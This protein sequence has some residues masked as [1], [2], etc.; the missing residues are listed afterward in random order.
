MGKHQKVSRMAKAGIVPATAVA[1]AAASA[2]I[3]TAAPVELPPQGGVT[4]PTPSTQ[5]GTTSTPAPPAEPKYWTEA[6]VV[7]PEYA[8]LPNYDYDT[9]ESTPVAYAP[10]LDLSTLHAPEP[11]EQAPIYIAPDEKILIGDY[12]FNQPNWVTDEDR[13]RTN[14]SAG[15]IRSQVATAWKSIGVDA[16]RADRIAAAQIGGAVIGAATGAAVTAVPG[17]LIGGTI[18]GIQGASLGGM[19][20]LGPLP[21]ITTGVAGTAIGAAA[22]GAVGAVPGALIGGA[23]GVIAGTAF[24]AGDE[25]GQPIE[26]ELPDI[27]EVALTEQAAGTV[28]QWQTSGPAGQATADAVRN[29][30]ETAPVVDAQVRQWVGSQPGGQ[31]AIEGVNNMLGTFFNGSLGTAAEMISTAIGGGITPV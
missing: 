16:E 28:E 2:G 10:P 18:G 11:V 31:D 25:E 17:A 19:V 13:E 5:G 23:A 30:V 20:P 12:H 6:P 8:P 27:Q 29:V 3:A 7:Q 4:A 1:I 26:V 24:G 22:G 21:A 14:N 15:L 9:G